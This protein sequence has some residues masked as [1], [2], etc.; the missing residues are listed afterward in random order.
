MELFVVALCYGQAGNN[1]D[2]DYNV[3]GPCSISTNLMVYLCCTL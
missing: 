1:V 3:C 2:N